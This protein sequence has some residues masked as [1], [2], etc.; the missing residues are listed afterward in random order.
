[1]I[2]DPRTLAIAA[3]KGRGIEAV[4]REGVP[5]IPSESAPTQEA[6]KRALDV[7]QE[8]GFGADIFAEGMVL[9]P[10]S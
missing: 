9:R 4:L 1:M 3:L 8:L 10:P 6:K 2:L 7:I 5:F